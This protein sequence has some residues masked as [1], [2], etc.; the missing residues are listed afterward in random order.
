M[1]L[2]S[3]S[4][5][6]LTMRVLAIDASLRN[7]GVAIIGQIGGGKFRALHFGVIQNPER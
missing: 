2:P 1:R 5:F 4:S 3:A 6:S 7:S